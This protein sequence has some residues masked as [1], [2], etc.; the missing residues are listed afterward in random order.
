MLCSRLRRLGPG[1]DGP[2][3]G[4]ARE[5][6]L[7]PREEVLRRRTRGAPS[8]PKNASLLDSSGWAEQ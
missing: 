5:F 3:V 2:L 4:I 6:V 8:M 1:K 7:R